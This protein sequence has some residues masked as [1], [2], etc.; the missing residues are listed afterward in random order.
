VAREIWKLETENRERESDDLKSNAEQARDEAQ[1]EQLRAQ[2]RGDTGAELGAFAKEVIT[3]HVQFPDDVVED[4]RD[5]ERR[6]DEEQGVPEHPAAEP[7][8]D[9]GDSGSGRG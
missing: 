4:N 1:E 8:P 9:S 6:V 3:D 2:A 5:P 7:R